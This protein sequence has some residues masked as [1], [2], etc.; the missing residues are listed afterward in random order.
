VAPFATKALMVTVDDPIRV[1][2]EVAMIRVT[3][4]ELALV[5]VTTLEGWNWQLAPTGRP[6]QESATEL[7]KEPAA[8]T[9]ND[10]EPLVEPGE[11]L[12]LP[13][14]GVEMAKSTMWSAKPNLW[15]IVA[16]SVPAAFRSK[17]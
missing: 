13:G 2:L 10:T 15:V 4:T 3:G 1:L 9:V 5:G 11:T 6:A 7:E 12:T 8:D 16:E 17:A 14:E